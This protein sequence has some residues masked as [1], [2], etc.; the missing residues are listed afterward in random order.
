MQEKP[1]ILAVDDEPANLKLISAAL[2]EDYTLALAKSAAMAEQFL[3]RKK[4]SLILLDVKMPEKDGITF[5]EELMEGGET[6]SIPFVFITSLSDPETRR[7]AKNLGAAG[8]V[9][10]PF[11]PTELNT[12]IKGIFKSRI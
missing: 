12:Y 7:K 1:L 10:K 9:E 4:P 2:S 8:Y 5:A 11:A 6:F 3:S